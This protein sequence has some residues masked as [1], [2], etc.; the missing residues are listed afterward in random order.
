MRRR[1]H[2]A[3]AD[4]EDRGDPELCVVRSCPGVTQSRRV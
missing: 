4:V 3:S 2:E 1:R